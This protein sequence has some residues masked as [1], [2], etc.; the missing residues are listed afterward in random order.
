LQQKLGKQ[1]H[2]GFLLLLCHRRLRRG[3]LRQIPQAGVAGASGGLM[4]MPATACSNARE[5]SR[6]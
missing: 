5:T 6:A 3:H 1:L 2:G 4:T